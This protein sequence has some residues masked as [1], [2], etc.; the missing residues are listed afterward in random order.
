M[1]RLSVILFS[2]LIFLTPFFPVNAYAAGVSVSAQ[3]AVLYE[4]TTGMILYEKNG[5]KRAPMAST[6]KIMTAL[7]ALEAGNIDRMITIEPEDCGVEGSS[8]Y[9]VAGEKLSLRELLYALLLQSANDAAV[10]IARHVGGS[11]EAFADMMNARVE[12]L[13]LK[14]THFMNPHGLDDP[15]HYTSAKDLAYIAAAALDN[16]TFAEIVSATKHTIPGR[17]GGV[18]VLVNHN[19]LL[20]MYKDAVGVK[21]GFTKKSGRCLVGAAEKDGLTFIT[22]TL[23][24]PNDWNDHIRLFEKGF[25]TL[26]NRL[27]AD[28]GEFIY[29][30]PM[31][32]KKNTYG[33]CTNEEAIYAP[34]PKNAPS[35]EVVLDLPHFFLGNEK[36]GSVIGRV[37]FRYNDKIIAQCPLVFTSKTR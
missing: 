31:A 7:V 12:T 21:T 28:A 17:D 32:D 26:E 34:L 27:I 6:T 33:Y 20:R 5:D 29:E 36:K 9:M 15:E 22:V 2:F 13:G 37:S 10:A 24:A 14:N 35:P 16:S 25:D 3:H 8:I 19:K 23:N 18:R 11:V 4:P 30:L 1:K